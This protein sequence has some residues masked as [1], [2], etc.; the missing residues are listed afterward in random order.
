MKRAII[1]SKKCKSCK[2][3]EVEAKCTM[4]AP[5]RES[6]DQKMWI[7]FYK[8]SGC[9]KCKTICPNEA[10]NETIKKG[11]KNETLCDGHAFAE[12]MPEWLRGQ[13]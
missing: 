6:P 11:N 13:Q 9:M 1:D 5:F 10:I 4:H 2:V 7:D 3:C 12:N 8:C